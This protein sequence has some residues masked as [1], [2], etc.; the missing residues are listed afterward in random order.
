MIQAPWS[1]TTFKL[2]QNIWTL[3]HFICR[4]ISRYLTLLD[5][6]DLALGCWLMLRQTECLLS[7]YHKVLS[8]LTKFV[9][10]PE[11]VSKIQSSKSTGKKPVKCAQCCQHVYCFKNL[12]LVCSVMKPHLKIYWSMYFIFFLAKVISF[13]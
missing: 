8:K 2:S 12:F 4:K 10:A 3:E 13:T 7:S 9:K 1:S 11:V 6:L 5:W